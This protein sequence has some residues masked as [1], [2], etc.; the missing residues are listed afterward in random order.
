MNVKINNN[1]LLFLIYFTIYHSHKFAT[2]ISRNNFFDRDIS[3]K[4]SMFFKIFKCLLYQSTYV[5][6]ISF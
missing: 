1:L 4:A 6:N 3:H 5:N 2:F